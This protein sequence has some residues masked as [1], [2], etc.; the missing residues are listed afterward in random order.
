MN[1]EIV[2]GLDYVRMREQ[3]AYTKQRVKNLMSLSDDSDDSG[4]DNDKKVEKETSAY[5]S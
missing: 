2:D 1:E 4:S 5:D 3:I